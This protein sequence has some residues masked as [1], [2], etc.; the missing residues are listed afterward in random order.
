M[1]MANIKISILKATLVNQGSALHKKVSVNPSSLF[2]N[3]SN[4][5]TSIYLIY[6]KY[7]HANFF[8]TG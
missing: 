2:M 5:N 1:K 8:F 7:L 6:T 3:T 4:K